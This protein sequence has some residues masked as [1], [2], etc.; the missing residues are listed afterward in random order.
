MLM[1]WKDT[2]TPTSSKFPVNWLAARNHNEPVT[3]AIVAT[4]SHESGIGNPSHW[5][6]DTAHCS[7]IL[8][9]PLPRDRTTTKAWTIGEC[10]FSKAAHTKGSRCDNA[11]F[12]MTVRSAHK[13]KLKRSFIYQLMQWSCDSPRA[14]NGRVSLWTNLILLSDILIA[15]SVNAVAKLLDVSSPALN[16]RT[17]YQSACMEA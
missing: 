4:L 16:F 10:I 9:Q 1:I 12:T 7:T 17:Y 6:G 13:L 2:P 8:R 15:D 14:L 3:L 11:K 5:L